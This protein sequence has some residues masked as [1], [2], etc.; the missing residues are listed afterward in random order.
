VALDDAHV[1]KEVTVHDIEPGSFYIGSWQGIVMVR[2]ERT[3]DGEAVERLAKVSTALVADPTYPRRSNVH[4]ISENAGVP[5]ASARAGFVDI[6]KEHA[7][8]MACVCIV[9]ESTGFLASAMRS[10]LTGMR[11]LA[12]RVFQY[13]LF[14]SVEEVVAWLPAEHRARTGHEIDARR[15]AQVLAGWARAE[16]K[17][18]KT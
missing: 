10:F 5:S 9:V 14:G 4:I 6:M 7:D 1:L 16:S 3:A 18:P 2:W 15:F 12:P 17:L 11:L 13:R 8:R